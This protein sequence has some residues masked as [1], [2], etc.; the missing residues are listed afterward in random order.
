MAIQLALFYTINK[1]CLNKNNKLKS[2]KSLKNWQ[3]VRKSFSSILENLREIII[4]LH[5]SQ[6]Q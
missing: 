6:S 1:F 5:Y 4:A 2:L 3:K